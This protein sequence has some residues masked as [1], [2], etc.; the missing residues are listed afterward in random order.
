MSCQRN[1]N[2]NL[3]RQIDLTSYEASFQKFSLTQSRNFQLTSSW[4]AQES[5]S[6][7]E[8]TVKS[9]KEDK[10]EKDK[11]V[12]A[13]SNDVSTK[14]K[15]QTVAEKRSMWQKVK[16]EMIHYYHGF[17]LLGLDVK[18]SA[19]LF[20]RVLHGNELTRREHKLVIK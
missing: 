10:E 14:T 8:D 19:K 16:A 11:T 6:K 9:L 20:W 1:I 4:R 12:V 5:S 17:R 15:E 13:A 2:N 18:V 7:V 3:R